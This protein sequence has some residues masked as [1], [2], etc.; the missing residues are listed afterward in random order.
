[1]VISANYVELDHPWQT[2]ANVL[3]DDERT[4]IA[5]YLTVARVKRTMVMGLVEVASSRGSR[6]TFSSSISQTTY[7]QQGSVARCLVAT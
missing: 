1:M 5:D 3:Y 2:S 7:R 6:T 4:L